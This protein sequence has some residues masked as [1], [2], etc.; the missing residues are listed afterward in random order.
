MSKYSHLKMLRKT[1]ARTQHICHKCGREI[2]TGAIYYREKIKDKFLHSLH[3]KK[4][5]S[6]CYEKYG[7]DLLLQSNNAKHRH[8]NNVTLDKFNGLHKYLILY[9]SEKFK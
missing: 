8:P 5:C 3:A 7:D 9:S 2:S 4:Y 1:K 6:V